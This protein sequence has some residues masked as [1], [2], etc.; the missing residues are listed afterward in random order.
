MQIDTVH[1]AVVDL[2]E[3][4]AFYQDVIGL[5]AGERYGDWQVMET[6]GDSVLAL[7]SGLEP[8]GGQRTVVSLRVMD[9]DGEAARIRR[10][11]HEPRESEPVDTG[12]ARFLTWADP[13]GT[14][15]QLIERR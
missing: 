3:A 13:W 2:E 10:H 15:I 5:Q 12:A 8:S 9:L 14:H 1:I 4:L 6:D 11:G 7:H